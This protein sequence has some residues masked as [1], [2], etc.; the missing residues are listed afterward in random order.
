MVG[1]RPGKPTKKPAQDQIS[2]ATSRPS[3][4]SDWLPFKLRASKSQLKTELEPSAHSMPITET[5][6]QTAVKQ[7][8][9]LDH[10]PDRLRTK[11]ERADALGRTP[12]AHLNAYAETASALLRGN[13]QPS[14]EMTKADIK[15]L[16]TLIE[17]ENA[18]HPGLDLRT[19]PDVESF[20]NAAA[21][22]DSEHFRAI[23]PMQFQNGDLPSGIHHV[24]ADV[25]TQPG[26]PPSIVFLEGGLLDKDRY[27]E[28]KAVWDILKGQGFDPSRIG[29]IEMG[30]QKSPNDCVMFALNFA[31]KSGDHQ[32]VLDA[33]HK[34]LRESGQLTQDAD[35]EWAVG[36]GRGEVGF[37][38]PDAAKKQLGGINFAVGADVLPPAFFKHTHSRT[39]A[40][41]VDQAAVEQTVAVKVDGIQ[42]APETGLGPLEQRVE[43]FRVTRQ[44]DGNK[45]QKSYSASIEGFRMQEIARA[46]THA[47]AT[48]DNELAEAIKLRDSLGS[49]T[50]ERIEAAKRVRELEQTQTGLRETKTQ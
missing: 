2:D 34:N 47:L 7:Q 14:I 46:K 50:L 12:D 36:G 8:S 24:M 27:E 32:P 11:L 40:K 21:A 26:E 44:P 10:L 5:S 6:A 33:M 38:G 4:M 23:V 29:V 17:T 9:S 35:F 37:Y 13:I 1:H 22:A 43:D 49:F 20:A 19:F 15:N 31:L 28:H 18:R 25:R 16:P 41:T 48:L 42:D 39:E 45:P 3:K 30:A